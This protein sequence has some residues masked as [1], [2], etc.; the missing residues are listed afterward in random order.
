ML[1]VTDVLCPVTAI[2]NPVSSGCRRL[3]FH[4][5]GGANPSERG[6]LRYVAACGVRSCQLGVG[7]PAYSIRVGRWSPRP[8]GIAT[9]R[10]GNALRII[11]RINSTSPRSCASRQAAT[12]SAVAA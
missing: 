1:A 6:T 12:A 11:R 10:S 7:L 2:R 5:V 9:A 3:I 8:E 4:S